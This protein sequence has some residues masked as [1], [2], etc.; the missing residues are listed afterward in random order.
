MLTL[1][2]K[3]ADVSMNVV[4]PVPAPAGTTLTASSMFDATHARVVVV[5]GGSGWNISSV[6][7]RADHLELTL[8]QVTDASGRTERSAAST[9]RPP[10][11]PAVVAAVAV[12]VAAA[13][14]SHPSGFTG[15]F[16]Y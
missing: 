5:S 10:R 4:L 15:E 14:S 3:S 6:P 1:S 13:G 16:S 2:S 11:V 8:M 7:T 12:V 9:N